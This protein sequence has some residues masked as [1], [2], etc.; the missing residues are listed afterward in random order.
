M[1]VDVAPPLVANV[2]DYDEFTGRFEAVDRIDLRA[3]VS[4]Y[5]QSVNFRDGQLVARGDVLFEIDPRPFEAALA[6]AQADLLAAQAEQ[7]RADADLV[8]AENLANNA[9]SEATRD[10]RRADK[11]RADAEVERAT[12]TVQSATLN[13]EYTEIKA[14]ASGRISDR[15][16]DVGNLVRSGESLLATIVSIKPIYFTFTASEA[17]FLKYSRLTETG[18]DRQAAR[19]N[20]RPVAVQLQD[21]RHWAREGIIDFVD[22]E[23]DPNSGTIRVRARFDNADDLLTPGLFGRLRVPASDEYEAMLVPDAAVL[24]DQSRK[25][26]LTVDAEGSVI[27]KIIELGPLYRGLRVIRSGLTADDQLIIAGVQRARPG[28]KVVAQPAEIAFPE[29]PTQ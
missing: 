27:P 8:R 1:P 25:V 26:V 14:E 22:N 10:Q 4:G 11:L 12:A 3:Q 7:V 29:A 17:D 20:E 6:S 16:V 15:K 24:S 13:L 9:I 5:L 28:S 18:G 21:E 23:L 2:I 19:E